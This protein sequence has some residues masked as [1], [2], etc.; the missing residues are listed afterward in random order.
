MW[1]NPNFN[2]QDSICIKVCDNGTPQLCNQV[3]VPITVTP[4][5]DAPVTSDINTTVAA[6]T[7]V[8]LNV[9][10]G[11]S[12]PDGDPLT[13][14][15]GSPTGMPAIL[16]ITGNGTIIVQPINL[17]DTGVV[18][19]HFTV[20]DNGSPSLCDSGIITIHFVPDSVLQ[21]TNF[22]PVAVNDNASTNPG[23]PVTV[24]VRGN[25]S[26]PN[27]NNTIGLP[28]I[29]TQPTHGTVSVDINGNL[30][31]TPN[32]GFNNANDTVTYSIC[33]NGTPSMCDTAIL[34]ISVTQNPTPNHAPVATDDFATTNEDTPITIIVK[35]NDKRP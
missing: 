29:V 24:N 28:T 34:V 22:P 5:N 19:I 26:D 4:V 30:V 9:A 13:Y 27:G 35:A 31:Y 12:D 10:A 25:D 6:G 21:N 16:T 32:T 3:M 7:S 15:Y 14:S 8:P 11:T 2:G 20:C 1:P 17:T 23:V 18:T 33:D